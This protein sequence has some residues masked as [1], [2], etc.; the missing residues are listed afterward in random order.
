M[1]FPASPVDGQVYSNLSGV[2]YKYNATDG[3]WNIE[4]AVSGYTGAQGLQGYTGA[5]GITGMAGTNGT[6]GTQ[7]ATGIQGPTNYRNGETINMQ[8]NH[9]S[10]GW[11]PSSLHVGDIRMRLPYTII[12]WHVTQQPKGHAKFWVV[13]SQWDNYPQYTAM[14]WGP[15]GPY[16]EPNYGVFWEPAATGLYAWPGA[17]GMDSD[18]LSI[19]ATECTGIQHATLSLHTVDRPE[20]ATGVIY[21]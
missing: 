19:Y 17:T 13:K 9:D 11:V 14:N 21:I 1:A 8:V 18:I 3:K 7:G 20:W 4:G 10:T 2:R 16:C 6:N 12:D 5:Q 15:T